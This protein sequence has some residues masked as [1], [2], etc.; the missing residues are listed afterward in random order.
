MLR[1]LTCLTTEHDWRLVLLAGLVCFF[2]SVA[3]V[4]LFHRARQTQHRARVTW[5]VTAGAAT[6]CGIWATH[7]IA[8]LAYNPGVSIG[9]D[10]GLSLLSLVA[11]VVVTGGGL[12]IAV[13]G[14]GRWAAPGGGAFVGFGIACMHYTGMWAVQ[15]PGTMEWV[16]GLVLASIGLGMLFGAMALIA[17]VRRDDIGG[18]LVAAILL[19]LAI[20]S[21]HFTAMGAVEILADPSRVIDAFSLSPVALAFAVANAAIAILGMSLGGAFA[22]RRLRE[23][24][25]RLDTAINNMSQ[26]LLMFDEAARLVISNQRYLQIYGLSAKHVKPG[27]TLR[28][29]IN[30]RLETGTYSGG[31]P[32]QYM[33]DLRSAMAQGRVVNKITELPDGRTIAVSS[34]PMAGGGWV[35]T[36]DDITEQKQAEKAVAAAR[37]EAERAELEARTAHARLLE[38]F[39]A[40][41]EALVLFDAEDRYVLWNRRYG[42]MYPHHNGIR[43]GM[44]FEESLR[45]G[46]SQGQHPEAKG[47]EEEWLAKRMALHGQ[48]HSSHEQQLA[49]GRWIRVEERRTADGGSIGIRVDITELKQREASFRLLFESN[50]IPMWVYEHATLRFI[51]V[52][53]AAIEHYGYSREQFLAMTLLDIRPPDDRDEVRRIAGTP[54]ADYRLGRT[55]RHQKADGTEI[56]VAVFFQP[57]VY[58]GRQASIGAI[59]DLTK[60]KEAEDELRRTREFLNTI[61][62]NVPALLVVKEARERR[63]VLVNREA[64]EF[65]GIPREQLIGKTAY[66]IFPKE[67]ADLMTARDRDVLRSGVPMLVGDNPVKTPGRGARL[68][69][70][71]RLAIRDERGEP[72]YLL[73][74]IEDV[75]ERRRAEERIAHLAH[76]DALTDLPN[77]A[78]FT[79]RI[80]STL[81]QAGRANSSFA[82]LCIDLDRFKEV[83]DIFGHSAGDALL[84]EVTRRLR[85]AADG[86]F[87][88]RVGGDEFTV[89]ATEGAQPVAA[90][91]LAERLLASVT[92]DLD[93]DGHRLRTDLS[94]GVA[95]YPTDGSDAA[96]LLANA[97]AALYRAKQE[98]RGTIR[99][100]EPDMDKRLRERR[101]LQHD[102]RSAVESGELTLHYQPQALIGGEIVGFEALLR[103]RHPSR[104]NVPPNIFIPLAE[105]SGL[106]ITIGE[107]VL[108]EACREAASWPHP[109][110]IAV[111][112]SPVQF[113]HG[114]LA[115]LVHS[116]LLETGLTPGR[117]ELEITEGV[118]IGDFSRAVSI[119]RR[120]KIVGVRIAMDDFG[121]GYSSLSYLQSFPFD[122]IKIDRAFISNVDCNPQSAAI[123]R[124]VIGLARGLSVPVVAEGVETRDQLAFLAREACDEVQGYLVGR[125]APIETYAE[126]VGRA[127][128]LK[129]M[130]AH[131]G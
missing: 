29:L 105:E 11:A 66:E 119:L 103:W 49:D 61:V 89:L 71:R 80:A 39:E 82:L 96:A 19:T 90:E 2:A 9:Y 52:N 112:L 32:E 85:Q 23:Q 72:Q 88:A 64:E 114:D 126:I 55:W 99:F 43:K 56:Q 79:E 70:S 129:P 38:A 44:Q 116:I 118:L 111:N 36:H 117:L 34:R 115:G 31:E 16:P 26:G 124:A 6:G 53:E 128:I 5:L 12:M 7:F 67:E 59:V 40:V 95:I 22:D 60:R 94:I 83:N 10:V 30:R 106:I 120:L 42:E 45:L 110:H 68:V 24:N 62:E 14:R 131:A 57:L 77:R 65:F 121:A 46:M 102:L 73:T 51:A 104:G 74:V 91:A 15:L 37:A 69:T 92:D 101:A 21:H 27:C 35:A 123:V 20:V 33:A 13:Y 122:T 125:P 3:A 48:T 75:T 1:V 50:P 93:V 113:R 87:L 28:Q 54:E 58:E 130:Q 97:D 47:R 25:M 41:P 98:G 86:A 76:H 78:A 4:N 109:L 107:W 18:T 8:M 127:A 84:R 81:D 63:Y 100:F 17:A 108:R